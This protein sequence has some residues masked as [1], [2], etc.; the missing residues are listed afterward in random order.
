MAQNT[1]NPAALVAN[2]RAIA[3]LFRESEHKM[4]HEIITPSQLAK[5]E[6]LKGPPCHLAYGYAP[7]RSIS[8]GDSRSGGGGATYPR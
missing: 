2:Q 5:L 4:L 6:Q 8:G 1:N 7:A 3:S